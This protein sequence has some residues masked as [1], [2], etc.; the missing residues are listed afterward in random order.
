MAGI[1]ASSLPDLLASIGVKTIED[2]TCGA[3]TTQ[4]LNIIAAISQQELNKTKK[5]QKLSKEFMTSAEDETQEDLG[6]EFKEGVSE[7]F[8]E[9]FGEEGF[10]AWLGNQFQQSFL[11]GM[12]S[13]LSPQGSTQLVNSDQFSPFSATD[14]QGNTPVSDTG[15]RQ[16]WSQNSCDA[17]SGTGLSTTFTRT[18]GAALKLTNTAG[19]LA[20]FTKHI[21]DNPDQLL[22]GFLTAA[23]TMLELMNTNNTLITNIL[24]NAA[25]IRDGV[26]ELDEE[27]YTNEEELSSFGNLVEQALSAT[28]LAEAAVTG[29]GEVNAE[30][31]TA[32]EKAVE[33]AAAW[34][35]TLRLGP[36][37][38]FSLKTVG[39][40]QLMEQQV[41]LYDEGNAKFFQLNTNFQTGF[42]TLETNARLDPFYV[43]VFTR[44]RCQL[45]AIRLEISRMIGTQNIALATR[46]SEWC[47]ALKAMQILM[48]RY[49]PQRWMTDVSASFDAPVGVAI[50]GMQTSFDELNDLGL[51]TNGTQ[52]VLSARRFIEL[53]R[54]ATRRY[55]TAA[56]INAAYAD[57]K[58]EYDR[59]LEIQREFQNALDKF[60]AD[61]NVA[62]VSK[63]AKRVLGIFAEVKVL[64]PVIVALAE[65]D[66]ETMFSAD[67]LNGSLERLRAAAIAKAAECC[68]EAVEG[69]PDA[70]SSAG[71]RAL[72]EKAQKA[73]DEERRDS[74]DSYFQ[75][76]VSRNAP[77][78]LGLFIRKI[79][80]EIR[81]FDRLMQIP[82][83]GGPALAKRYF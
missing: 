63:E 15:S 33:D 51:D 43:N 64:V 27:D 34:A 65:A 38:D 12:D 11:D 24:A 19:Q 6:K 42:D 7:A 29:Q 80:S 14:L 66:Y 13:P 70:Q 56:T 28:K 79:K 69:V 5:Q 20:G 57:L 21:A 73:R 45:D 16:D 31:A 26:V 22:F 4:T 18:L 10:D 2:L 62:P 41:N 37:Y 58:A 25:T 3:I 83:L 67:T 48:S 76:D 35:C 50:K 40:I 53:A 36:V 23:E 44:V 39:L 78:D 71:L 74:F 60:L 68:R 55:T 75:D 77:A 17:S 1:A 32:A 54:F 49:S 47:V 8:T 46:Q 59:V 82:C 81:E 9:A 61:N 52:F 72:D 30:L